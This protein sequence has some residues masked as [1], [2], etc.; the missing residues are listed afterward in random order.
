MY[1]SWVVDLPGKNLGTGISSI[2]M[3]QGSH[4]K[5]KAMSDTDV[6][7]LPWKGIRSGI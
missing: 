3:A 1:F 6:A 5:A 7:I 2:Q 4:V